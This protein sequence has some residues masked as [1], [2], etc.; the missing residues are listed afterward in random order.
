MTQ[1]QEKAFREE[2]KALVDMF[3]ELAEK[4]DSSYITMSHRK[5]SSCS[6]LCMRLTRDS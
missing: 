3:H 5:V 2:L 1:E 6:W 4:N